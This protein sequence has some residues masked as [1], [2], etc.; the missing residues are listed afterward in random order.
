[1]RVRGKQTSVYLLRMIMNAKTQDKRPFAGFRDGLSSPAVLFCKMEAHP[2]GLAFSQSPIHEIGRVPGFRFL[3]VSSSCPGAGLRRAAGWRTGR[4]TAIR[5]VGQSANPDLTACRPVK[6]SVCRQVV[7]LSG[8]P[9]V[10]A[11]G[12]V[13]WRLVGL[14]TWRPVGLATCQFVGLSACRRQGVRAARRSLAKRKMKH[15]PQFFGFFLNNKGVFL[16]KNTFDTRFF[17]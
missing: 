1:M 3:G 7:L 10:R 11:S 16:E 2:H 8:C 9:V 14:L 15:C 6:L 13:V 5:R 12:R 4:E 17:S